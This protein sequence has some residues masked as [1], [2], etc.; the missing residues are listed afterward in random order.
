[1]RWPDWAV[2][3]VPQ[4]SSEEQETLSLWG[5]KPPQ[6][7][8][9]EGTWGSRQHPS[10]TGVGTQVK[11]SPSHHLYLHG[12]AGDISMEQGDMS[13]L[14]LEAAEELWLSPP[15][16]WSCSS[17]CPSACPFPWP[18]PGAGHVPVAIV[19]G[20]RMTPRGQTPDCICRVSS[21]VQR[22]VLGHGGPDPG[23]RLMWGTL[24]F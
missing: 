15:R 11:S 5:A 17:P 22:R 23:M 7:P 18:L 24:S 13:P 6:M 12:R 14:Q 16:T 4:N 3:G 20:A 21:T 19:R 9:W 8:P 2:P 1:M 10:G